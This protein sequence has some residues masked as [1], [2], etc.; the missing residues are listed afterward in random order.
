MTLTQGITYMHEHVTIDLSGIKQTD[1]TNLRC[2]DQTVAE[3][4]KLY[5]KGVR[6]IV[7][8]TVAGMRPDPLY[9]LEVAEQS[10]INIVQ[11]TGFYT[12]R[13]LPPFVQ[14]NCVDQLAQ[15]MVCEIRDGIAGTPVKADIIGEI[16]SSK[17]GFTPN[18]QKVF[19]AAVLAHK[20]TGVPITTHATLGTF[21]YEQA[22]FFAE[23]GVDTAKVL[24]GH[25][26]LCAD[27]DYALNVL[28]QGVYVGFDTVGK[29]NYLPDINRVNML[30]CI[31]QAGYIERVVLSMD[32]TRRSNMEH[33]G[34]IGY[35]YLLDCFVP[36]LRKNG[37]K[38]DSIEN[39]LVK[40]P[41]RF[42]GESV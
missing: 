16:G 12:E 24:I 9:V 2:F 39:L 25:I 10:G 21:G 40:N 34:G 37:L 29:E 5:A 38:E 27:A 13:F 6:N 19:E 35:S 18:E 11:A 32:I 8:V 20:E 23:R 3:F 7:D 42:F 33:T 41:R 17:G 1:D 26:D 30:Q 31:E 4:K 28:E 36:L 15:Y 14:T 22:V